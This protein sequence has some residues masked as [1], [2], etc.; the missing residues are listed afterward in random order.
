MFHKEGKFRS[1]NNLNLYY[2][3]WQP[4]VIPKAVLLVVHGLAEHSGRYTNL[5]NY[6]V[7]GNYAIYALDHQGHGRSEGLP[8]YVNSFS[9][10]LVDLK[11]FFELVRQTH[12]S[13]KIYLVGHSMGGL[14]AASYAAQYP[15]DPAG[16][17][18]SSPTL[19]AGSSISSKD[20]LMARI[21]AALLPKMGIA[22]LDSS[23]ISRDKKVIEAYNKDP[24]VHHG[25]I[26]AR[27]ACELLKAMDRKL[28]AQMSKIDLP[29]LIMQGSLDRLSNPDGSQR[30][31]ETVKS[32]DK[33]LKN[34]EGLY[35]ELF[36]EP[37]HSQVLEFMGNWLNSRL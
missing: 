20:I 25:K 27:L 21:T 3:S 4:Q 28:T 33:T 8:G 7:L 1:Q 17:A 24:L 6:F 31:F 14:I 19:K 15:E 35:H 18:L 12:Q 34:F 30:L 5:V 9:D 29:I 23:A 13:T 22:M 2:Q 37:E 26:K 16:L 36:N 11:T 32:K 10:Y